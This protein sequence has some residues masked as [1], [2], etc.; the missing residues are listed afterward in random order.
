MNNIITV[1]IEV[2]FLF[3]AVAILAL[4]Y[5]DANKLKKVKKHGRSNGYLTRL[6]KLFK[7]CVKKTVRRKWR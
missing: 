1:S 4:V 6:G 5:V 3:L 7:R 2:Q